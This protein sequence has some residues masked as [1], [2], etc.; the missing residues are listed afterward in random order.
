MA[1]KKTTGYGRKKAVLP[2]K[3]K[4]LKKKFSRSITITPLQD[5]LVQQRLTFQ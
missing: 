4:K 3:P 1:G 5:I 2:S